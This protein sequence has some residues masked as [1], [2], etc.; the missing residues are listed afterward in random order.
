MKGLGALFRGA[1]ALSLGEAGLEVSESHLKH[2]LVLPFV[3]KVKLVSDLLSH[4]LGTANA[5]ASLEHRQREDHKSLAV[6]LSF[7]NTIQ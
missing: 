4:A 7:T 1:C 6:P 5:R 3:P 2:Q